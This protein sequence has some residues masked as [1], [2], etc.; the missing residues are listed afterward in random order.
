M[1]NKKYDIIKIRKEWRM[2]MEKKEYK[3]PE[4]EITKFELEDLLITSLQ[5]N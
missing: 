5:P 2:I 4:M 1:E 3:E